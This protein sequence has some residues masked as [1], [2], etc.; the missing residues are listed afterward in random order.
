M[1]KGGELVD[2]KIWY[3][4]AKND[5]LEKEVGIYWPESAQMKKSS[6]IAL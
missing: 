1:N 3:I 5:Y 6:Y 2:S 4:P